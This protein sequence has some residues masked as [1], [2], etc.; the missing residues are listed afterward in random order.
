MA[1]DMNNQMDML[2][3]VSGLYN[4]AKTLM[5]RIG[6]NQDKT[7]RFDAEFEKLSKQNHAL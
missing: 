5:D 1:D 2:I 7:D 3:K 4:M 6:A